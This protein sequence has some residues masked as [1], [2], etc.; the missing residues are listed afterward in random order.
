MA[1][2]AGGAAISFSGNS[3]SRRLASSGSLV[4]ELINQTRQYAI[5]QNTMS[6]LVMV[7]TKA[8]PAWDNRLFIIMS[9]S[10]SAQSWVPVSKWYSLSPG[11]AVDV[12]GAARDDVTTAT[13]QN[14]PYPNLTVPSTFGSLT[15]QGTTIS[16]SQMSYEF[17]LPSGA[18]YTQGSTSTSPPVIRLVA[19]VL[20]NGAMSYMGTGGGALSNYYNIMLNIYTGLPI[21]NQP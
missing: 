10:D 13:T 6:V 3:T 19:G 15:Y 8:N 4:V 18:I 14:F 20:N 11:I 16:T 9:Y 2:L 17:F 12:S 7:N 21:V 1:I 5:A